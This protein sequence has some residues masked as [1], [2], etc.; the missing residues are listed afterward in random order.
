MRSDLQAMAVPHSNF[1]RSKGLLAFDQ[2][3][4]DAVRQNSRTIRR[5]VG[6]FADWAGVPKATT[7]MLRNAGQT[8]IN[9]NTGPEAFYLRKLGRT[10]KGILPVATR[11]A[12]GA[13]ADLSSIE[14]SAVHS[15]MADEWPQPRMGR[16]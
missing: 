2:E 6:A 3:G 14:R 8:V 15:G 1:G 10:M 5:E 4:D 9:V 16:R 12:T 13:A 11:A 7:A